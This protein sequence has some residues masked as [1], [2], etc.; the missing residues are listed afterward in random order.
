M[1]EQDGFFE[2]M[3]KELLGHSTYQ[4]PGT[5]SGHRTSIKLS[6]IL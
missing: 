5:Y 1:K 2:E 3:Y 4:Q 6:E